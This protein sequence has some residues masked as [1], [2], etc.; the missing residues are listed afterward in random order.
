MKT[1]DE[2]KQKWVDDLIKLLIIIRRLHNNGTPTG[3]QWGEI[4]QIITSIRRRGGKNKQWL[5]LGQALNIDIPATA[6]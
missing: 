4:T 6:Q 5:H 1:G 2:K 3:L